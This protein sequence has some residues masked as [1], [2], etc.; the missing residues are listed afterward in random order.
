MYLVGWRHCARARAVRA[1]PRGFAPPGAPPGAL[2]RRASSSRAGLFWRERMEE[3]KKDF[4][5]FT[6]KWR[7][8]D[9]YDRRDMPKGVKPS[10]FAGYFEKGEFVTTIE[11]TL[12]TPLT[13]TGTR[14]K[15][16][17][18]FFSWDKNV[19]IIVNYVNPNMFLTFKDKAGKYVG[20]VCYKGH[21]AGWGFKPEYSFRLGLG[22]FSA[23][24]NLQLSKI[25]KD[26][27]VKGGYDLVFLFYALTRMDIKIPEHPEEIIKV[28]YHHLI[29]P[30]S[31]GMIR[32]K[33]GKFKRI[34]SIFIDSWSLMHYLTAIFLFLFIYTLF[35]KLILSILH[36][37]DIL[38]S[39]SIALG[40]QAVVLVKEIPNYVSWLQEKWV[41]VRTK[42][43]ESIG[44]APKKLHF[45]TEDLD[46]INWDE[47]Y[48]EDV[49]PQ[50]V[51]PVPGWFQRLRLRWKIRILTWWE[52]RKENHEERM[53]KLAA[54]RMRLKE[55][56]ETWKE[57]VGRVKE[58]VVGPVRPYWEK[59]ALRVKERREPVV[60]WFDEYLPF[61]GSSLRKRREEALRVKEK[62]RLIWY[63]PPDVEE[64]ISILREW[65]MLKEEEER[66]RREMSYWK[67][68]YDWEALVEG[69]HH[70][71]EE[72]T[73]QQLPPQPQQE[74]QSEN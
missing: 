30:P 35:L 1:S 12:S 18:I 46:S 65:R 11:P 14:K 56:K 21:A 70:Q 17:L 32:F 71:E 63:G 52:K 40:K 25:P 43:E 13:I 58:A 5:A 37:L 23:P 53:V 2:G 31:L 33:G 24:N 10:T 3:G 6:E 73:A 15:E 54:M 50:R 51:D 20:P 47:A 57:R 9:K 68:D 55:R 8:F 45:N 64:F 74:E 60:R 27:Y 28:A 48:A 26:L 19:S 42:I 38:I 7:E 69:T 16:D 61:V 39:S 36:P 4:E 49:V 62:V 44:T 22:F 59:M 72:E 29:F 41:E 67:E 34:D 66:I